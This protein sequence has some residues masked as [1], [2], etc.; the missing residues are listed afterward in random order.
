MKLM[1]VRQGDPDYSID[2]LTE[3]GKRERANR[4]LT[5]LIFAEEKQESLILIDE[6]INSATFKGKEP[7]N[8]THDWLDNKGKNEWDVWTTYIQDKENTIW[9]AKLKVANTTNG[10]KILYDVYP[11]EKVGRGRTMRSHR[12]GLCAGGCS[13]TGEPPGQNR[14]GHFADPRTF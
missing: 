14:G 2:G 6:I 3:K 4:H 1:I 9:E 12:P 10:E 11:I 7:A 8:H 13:G 5:N